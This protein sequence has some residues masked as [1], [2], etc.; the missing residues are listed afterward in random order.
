VRA[1]G[2]TVRAGGLTVRAGGLTVRA[3]GLTVWA[4]GLTERAGGLTVRAG[5]LTVRAGGLTV[6]AGGLTVRS[7]GDVGVRPS[8]F[9]GLLELGRNSRRFIDLRQSH[10]EGVAAR[11][12]SNLRLSYCNR[13][14]C[15]LN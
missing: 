13:I 14:A 2:L 3:G 5:G 9:D 8:V 15:L 11:S 12:R 10:G 6:W 1:G 7:G 4:R